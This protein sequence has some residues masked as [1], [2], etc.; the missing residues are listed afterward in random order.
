MRLNRHRGCI[1][2]HNSKLGL[3][4]E[5]KN[6]F[7]IRD[8]SS[9]KVFHFKAK[10]IEERRLW[11]THL[12]DTIRQKFDLASNLSSSLEKSLSSLKSTES[13]TRMKEKNKKSEMSKLGRLE[14]FKKNQNK[15]E[16]II[17]E[18]QNFNHSPVGIKNT[19]ICTDLLDSLEKS[20]QQ[21][22]SNNLDRNNNLDLTSCFSS[23]EEEDRQKS[24]ENYQKTCTLKTPTA[25]AMLSRGEDLISDGTSSSSDVF[26][27]A[28]NENE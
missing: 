20:R 22:I 13:S 3:D 24:Q 11:M 5:D 17:Q 19:E 6:N 25:E 12:E 4:D 16:C 14:Q 28:E 8:L 2:L 10:D 27:D 9:D 7:T 15:L 1:R 26:F 21:I 18:I 23:D